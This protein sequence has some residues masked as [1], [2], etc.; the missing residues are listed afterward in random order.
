MKFIEC[1][2]SKIIND[3]GLLILF[4]NGTTVQLC[5]HEQIIDFIVDV[6]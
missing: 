5:S 6:F 1:F 2:C 4:L 3:H